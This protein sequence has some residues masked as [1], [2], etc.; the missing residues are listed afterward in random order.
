VLQRWLAAARHF[1]AGWRAGFAATVIATRERR[2]HDTGSVRVY[3]RRTMRQWRLDSARQRGY[4]LAHERG[5]RHRGRCD[6]GELG[7]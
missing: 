3:W 5:H 4:T 6:S 1:T 2:L 7:L